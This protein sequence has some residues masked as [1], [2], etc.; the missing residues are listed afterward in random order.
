[1]MMMMMM[2]KL[3]IQ[4]YPTIQNVSDNT[5][6]QSQQLSFILIYVQY[7]KKIIG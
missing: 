4:S 2:R 1:M 6:K 3:S 5:T 7:Q